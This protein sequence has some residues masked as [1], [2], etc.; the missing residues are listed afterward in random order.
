MKYRP[1]TKGIAACTLK[2]ARSIRGQDETDH[3]TLVYRNDHT[4]A[5]RRRS[6]GTPTLTVARSP[7]FLPARLCLAAAS[8]M[9]SFLSSTMNPP[10]PTRSI[11]ASAIL[12]LL[13]C[14]L[15]DSGSFADQGDAVQSA[16]NQVPDRVD[17]STL[18][19]KIMCGYQ[20]WFSCEGDGVNLGLVHWGRNRLQP[21]GPNNVTVDLWPDMT[22][23]DPDERFP[24]DFRHANGEQAEVF[25]SANPKTVDRHFRWMRDYGID[26]V[27]LQRFA[28][29]LGNSRLQP[30]KD[31]V[32][33]HTR[34]SAEQH[35]RVYA[36]MYDL[37]GLRRDQ[38]ARVADDW[39]KL[40]SQQ[41]IC[42]DTSYLHH[43]GKPV[44]AVWGIGFGDDRD[45]TLEECDVLV[46]QLKSD[47]CTVMLGVPSWWRTQERDASPSPK[48]HSILKK[49]DI[50]SPWT[51]GRYRT[52]QQAAR[53]ATRVWEPDLEW[54]REREIDFLPVVY[55]GFSW[56]NLN[57]GEGIPRL[58]G[59]FFW[60]QIV[61]AK[62]SGAEMIYVAMF[63]E[64]DEGTAIFKCTNDPPV[65]ESVSF[66]TY[67]GL[68]SDFY[69][70]LTGKAG[71]LLR[72]EIT[73]TD[74]FS[75]P[76]RD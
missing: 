21:M 45:Y 71:Q 3:E 72:G 66:E 23:L 34:K 74:G 1:V 60:S 16:T 51:V 12:M 54:C 22:E 25:S 36:V 46:D 59:Q 20:G 26:G 2:G 38:V 13:T 6:P 73:P 19:G 65:S 31:L 41:Q 30:Q 37:S 61:A 53:H 14:C 17:A 68:P 47:G 18:T 62:E 40:K 49:A 35:G 43:E 63:D 28:N 75:P 76:V 42:Q 9:R 55:P 69:L 10:V 4:I 39:K 5:V 64:V 48:L 8:P 52:P 7:V 29:G 11:V 15:P 24:T 32:L 33:D 58:Q 27:F 50:L 57:G 44:V 67:E 56:K 70:W